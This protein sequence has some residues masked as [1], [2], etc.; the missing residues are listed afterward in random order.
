MKDESEEMETDWKPEAGMMRSA[1]VSAAS[2]KGAED[3][4]LNV[5]A[6]LKVN[7][8]PSSTGAVGQWWR[9]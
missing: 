3:S 6:S 4:T 7:S 1:M 5:S 2:V 9:L 8:S